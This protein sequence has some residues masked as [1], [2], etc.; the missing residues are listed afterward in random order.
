MPRPLRFV[1]TPGALVEVTTRAI[2]GRLLLRP[3][4]ATNQAILGVLGRAQKMY[5]MV[6]HSVVFLSNH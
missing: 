1:P 5:D 6:V 4:P 2:H 3:S